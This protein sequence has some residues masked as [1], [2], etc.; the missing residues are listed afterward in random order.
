MF[1]NCTYKI[2][3]SCLILRGHPSP[4][5]WSKDIYFHPIS[6]RHYLLCCWYTILYHWFFFTGSTKQNQP[7][8]YQVTGFPTKVCLILTDINKL[9]FFVNT[10]KPSIRIMMIDNWGD[11]GFNVKWILSQKKAGRVLM[12][13][14]WTVPWS[15]TFQTSV[16]PGLRKISSSASGIVRPGLPK[17]WRSTSVF[18]LCRYFH[19]CEIPL[20]H[21][22]SALTAKDLKIR[23]RTS[24]LLWLL[25]SWNSS[26]ALPFCHHS[27]RCEDTLPHSCFALTAKDV[28]FCLLSSAVCSYAMKD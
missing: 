11:L 24:A 23:F 10:T 25:N 27:R 21:F 5:I 20:P 12:H 14:L 13:I 8:I 22:C 6:V 4:S 17:M 28:Q 2:H 9:I 7:N 15:S 16:L 3:Q 19:R 1:K 18:H 26:S